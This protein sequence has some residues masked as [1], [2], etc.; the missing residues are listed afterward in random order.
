[1][2]G[3]TTGFGGDVPGLY[4]AFRHGYPGAVLDALAAV[5]SLTDRDVV[6][7]VGCGTGQL[8]L[9]LARRV[10]A[11]IGLDPEPGMLARARLAAAEA[12]VPNVAWVLGG[13]G[14]LPAL[15]GLL[16]DGSVAAVT[17]AQALHWMD[18]ERLF[19]TAF[20]LVRPGG[21]VAVVTNGTPLWLQ[22]SDWSLAL[23]AFLAG[24]LGE[25]PVATCG[26]DEA[27]QRRYRDALAAAGYEVTAAAADYVA[28]LSLDQ[29][30]GG[31]LSAL[32]DQLPAPGE[33]A[34]FAA[35]VR[36][37]LPSAGPFREHVHVAVLAGCRR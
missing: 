11:A 31:L 8:T 33:R 23:R 22:D 20:P 17:V 19:R 10:R 26:T 35:R 29:L 12:G 13:D 3:V 32:G 34:E 15:A 18:C 7:D 4:H 1:M 27:S 24:W 16:G 9:P 28:E 14:D 2:A 6:L 30:T 36:R 21:G 37:A 25:Q 5:F